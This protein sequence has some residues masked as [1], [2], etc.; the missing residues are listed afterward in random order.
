MARLRSLVSNVGYSA[1]KDLSWKKPKAIMSPAGQI[2]FVKAKAWCASH[3]Q[4]LHVFFFS[5]NHVS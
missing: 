2:F 4:A 5:W 1:S 3:G